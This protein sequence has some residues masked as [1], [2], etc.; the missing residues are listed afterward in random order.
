MP[1]SFDNEEGEYTYESAY[2]E[3]E[4]EEEVQDPFLRR[5]LKEE[6]DPAAVEEEALGSDASGAAK[7]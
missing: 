5:F 4:T 1:S 7:P 2:T 3:E 6:M